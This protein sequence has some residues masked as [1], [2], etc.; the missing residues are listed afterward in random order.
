MAEPSPISERDPGAPIARDAIDPD[1]VRLGR[2]RSKIG[3]I[4]AAGVVVLCAY[5]LIRLGPD[6]R[7]AG[8]D[9]Q[10]IAATA[11]DLAAGKV[12]ADSYVAL[13]AEPVRAHAIRATK[14]P[15]DLGYRV[16][17]VRGTSDRLWLVLPGD[18][19][20][21]P[22]EGGYRGRLRKLADLPFAGVV[23][24]YAAAH[25]R[26]VFVRPAE[27]AAARTSGTLVTVTG[28]RVAVRAGDVVAYDVVDP[29]A[30]VVI[31][32]FTA[33]SDDHGPLTDAA[34]WTKQLADLGIAATPLPEPAPTDGVLGQARFAVALPAS[35]LTA[36]LE[37]A[38]LWAARVEPVT[39]HHE[40]TWG[41]PERESPPTA[42]LVA[43]FAARA[44][45]ADAYAL[46]THELPAD[47][48]YVL[49]IT[50]VLAGLGL[51]FAWALIRAVRRDLLP[52]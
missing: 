20:D 47:Y 32:T 45:P 28:D 24:A 17:P 36:R 38:K 37:A 22:R 42:E 19:W 12:A 15:T 50:V 4:T 30:S 41:A 26:P 35:E 5:F 14:S 11:A 9:E 8:A 1:L 44:I 43:V 18:G 40:T 34:A 51:L 49:P 6:R 3:I 33:K 23:S 39:R 2:P 31:A 7:F 21:K 52:A 25:P 48:W 10:P 29:R 16:A 46:L 27:L 13:T